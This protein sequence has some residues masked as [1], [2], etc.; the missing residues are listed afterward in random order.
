MFSDVC[1]HVCF[2]L[3]FCICPFSYCLQI[4]FSACVSDFVFGLRCQL[5]FSDC[6]FRYVFRCCVQAGLSDYVFRCGFSAFGFQMLISGC[7]FRCCLFPS[8]FCD[9]AFLFCVPSLFSDVVSILCFHILFSYVR[10]Q[11]VQPL[12]SDYVFGFWFSD[13]DVHLVFKHVGVQRMFADFGCQMWGLRIC[14]VQ[15]VCLDCACICCLRIWVFRFGFS[16]CDVRVWFSDCVLSCW[17]SELG[18]QLWVFRLCFQMLFSACV[19]TFCFQMLV[20]IVRVQMLCSAVGFGFSDLGF[21]IVFAC[22][23]HIVFSDVGFHIWVCRFCF[24]MLLSDYVCR[25]GCPDCG[26]QIRFPG[27]VFRCCV[28]LLVCIVCFEI[29]SC[30]DFVFRCCSQIVISDVGSN[31][32]FQML[33]FGCRVQSLLPD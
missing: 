29:L 13:L 31:L 3:L 19:S 5:L 15:S 6:V 30:S 9:C 22:C 1:F 8:V 12:L 21:Q 20:C 25:S 10:V 24:R 26:C 23:V 27:V 33:G 32:C 11:I 2:H 7:V 28:L 16:Q 14:C 17:L 18:V 4:V